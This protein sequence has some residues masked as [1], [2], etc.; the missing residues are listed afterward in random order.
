MAEK[1]VADLSPSKFNEF[2][3]KG[4]VLVDFYADWC[5]PC[6]TMSPVVESLAEKF[7]GKLKFG[8]LNIDDGNEIAQKLR[9][10]SIPTFIL[11]KD[12]KPSAQF[13]GS[14]SSE[15]FEGKIRKN[16]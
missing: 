8:K 5:M 10:S 4:K 1:M 2:I 11:F 16:I 7:K 9:I 15:D 14:M 12:G 3:G 13:T 6:L